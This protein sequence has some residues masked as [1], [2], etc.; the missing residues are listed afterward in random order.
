ML[1]RKS[2]AAFAGALVLAATAAWAD[3]N[4]GVTRK[5]N[6]EGPRLTKAAKEGDDLR[7][8][9]RSSHIGL[10]NFPDAMGSRLVKLFVAACAL[11]LVQPI[12]DGRPV[13]EQVHDCKTAKGDHDT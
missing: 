1:N 10:T 5:L 8:A 12:A 7:S 9:V 3:I 6:E 2:C 4:V 13:Q 11:R